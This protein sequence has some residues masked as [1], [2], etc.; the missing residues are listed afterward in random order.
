MATN[1]TISVKYNDID[2]EVQG[3]YQRGYPATREQPEEYPEFNINHV[4]ISDVDIYELLSE[5]QLSEIEQLVIE[6][7]ANMK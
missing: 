3:T 6:E 4:R 5:E 2:I 1:E 7:I